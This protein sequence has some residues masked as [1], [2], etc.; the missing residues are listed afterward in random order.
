MSADILEVLYYDRSSGLKKCRTP[1]KLEPLPLEKVEE[2]RK[3][4]CKKDPK[5]GVQKLIR[6]LACQCQIEAAGALKDHLNGEKHAKAAEKF[7]P[8]PKKVDQTLE[9][10]INETDHF[11]LGLEKVEE[12]VLPS[13]ESAVRLY[14]CQVFDCDGA[15]GT[16]EVFFKHLVSPDHGDNYFKELDFRGHVDQDTRNKHH[17]IDVSKMVTIRDSERYW[18]QR[19]RSTV[20]RVSRRFSLHYL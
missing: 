4:F 20:R 7:V 2:L 19:N 13:D 8:R 9:D 18:I 15:F 3:N 17:C 11:V 6:C 1:F 10:F 16:P 14:K 12:F 5:T